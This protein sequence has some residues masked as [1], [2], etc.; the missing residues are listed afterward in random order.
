LQLLVL[1]EWCD[2]SLRL[3]AAVAWVVIRFVFGAEP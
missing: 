3:Q 2:F 1:Y